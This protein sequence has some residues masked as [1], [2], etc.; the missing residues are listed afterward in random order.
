MQKYVESEGIDYNFIL[1]F[2]LL[3]WLVPIPIKLHCNIAW[4]HETFNIHWDRSKR[5]WPITFL[6]LSFLFSH[7]SF[8][9]TYDLYLP[10][11]WKLMLMVNLMFFP[12]FA[13]SFLFIFLLSSPIPFRF[14]SSFLSQR[15]FFFHAHFLLL[16]TN[17]VMSL[18]NAQIKLNMSFFFYL[19]K[20]FT[21]HVTP[22]SH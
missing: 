3:L 9:P 12:N 11:A 20:F 10:S 19:F 15:W 21:W 4:V 2:T 1:S 13:T 16:F 17:D 8:Y 14:F 18:F 22:L 7:L 5:S 6:F